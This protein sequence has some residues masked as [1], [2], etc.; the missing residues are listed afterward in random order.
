MEQTR[1]NTIPRRTIATFDR[2]EDAQALVA[3]LSDE[4]FPVEHLAIVGTDLRYVEKVT[5]RLN[6]GC[7]ALMGA[8][9]STAM[10]A[11]FGLLFALFSSPDVPSRGGLLEVPV[12]RQA[13]A[14]VLLALGV[15]GS[16]YRLVRLQ[17]GAEATA[18][19]CGRRDKP[20]Q[21]EQVPVAGPGVEI[22]AHHI[23][24]DDEVRPRQV[25]SVEADIT[26]EHAGHQGHQCR[27]VVESRPFSRLLASAIDLAA[28][29]DN[30]SSDA[31]LALH[32]D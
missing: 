2:Y 27:G 9:G 32:L 17:A 12:A 14:P 24:V 29:K 30:R 6:A 21:D 1:T 23:R 3:R 8:G 31:L 22:A 4:G 16:P 25:H 15:R 20:G 26:D 18:D 19:S 5:G 13:V 28:A 10:G 7:A 11:L